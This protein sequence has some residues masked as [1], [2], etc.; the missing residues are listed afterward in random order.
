MRIAV[1]FGF[2]YVKAVNENRKLVKFPSVVAPIISSVTGG[3]LG[4]MKDDY[5]IKFDGNSYYVG[6]AA[7][8]AGGN[9]AWEEDASKNQFL[10]FLAATAMFELLD[11]DEPVDLAVGLPMSV[12]NTQ[13]QAISDALKE[14]KHEVSIGST[15]KNIKVRSVFVFPQ[16][17]GVFYAAIHD[18]DGTVKNQNLF[19][20]QVGVIDV[21]HRT[22]DV[23]YMARGR[24]G[25][26]PLDNLSK[27]ND[28]GM[29]EAH[30]EIQIK[31]SQLVG[32][33]T[34]LIEIEKSLLWFLGEFDYKGKTYNLQDIQ[35]ATYEE[36]AYKIV[37]WVKQLWGD[38]IN[39]LHAIFIAGGGGDSL[40][41]T[42]EKHLPVPQK[43]EM[44]E[45]ANA[46]G[47][48]A[49]QALAMEMQKTLSKE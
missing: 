3:S 38:S 12:Y 8:I 27:S 41:P 32:G 20:K 46:F 11:K 16:S 30:Q 9:R 15:T 44:P 35:K 47:F 49:A 18:I 33:E 31:A 23:L 45:Y 2:G 10:K 36:H 37:S 14:F 17:A 13:K 6:D 19:N 29:N 21:G 25:L 5:M 22:V 43:V 1:D 7:M 34:D 26:A 39:N 24:K 48:L 42:M 28:L 4:Y 40:Y